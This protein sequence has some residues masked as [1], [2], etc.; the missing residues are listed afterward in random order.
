MIM[1]RVADIEFFHELFNLIH[2]RVGLNTVSAPRI[3]RAILHTIRHADNDLHAITLGKFK[4]LARRRRVLRVKWP[5][6]E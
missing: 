4:L 3:L 1:N 6:R 5:R 2:H